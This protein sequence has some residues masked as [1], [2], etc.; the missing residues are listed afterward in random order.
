MGMDRQVQFA[1]GVVPS[2]NAIRE[3]LATQGV[4]VQL[5]MIDGELAFPDEEPAEHWNELRV[6]TADGQSI[7]LRREDRQ[8]QLVV[9]GNADERLV[10]A[11]NLLTWAVAGAGQGTIAMP[12]GQATAEQFSKRLHLLPDA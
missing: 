6:A 11:W 3:R 9:W 7:T 2:W 5:R 12:E 4:S 10:R 8:V 1:G